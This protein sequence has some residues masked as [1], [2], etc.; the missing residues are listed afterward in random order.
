M[1]AEL[2]TIQKK[3]EDHFAALNA[4]RKD[5]GLPVFALEH[6]LSPEELSTVSTMLRAA[7]KTHYYL[8][9]HWLVWVVY[10]TEQGY[11]YDGDEY[12]NT[13]ER[14]MP[15]WD[16]SWRPN[17]RSWFGRF[18]KTYGGIVPVGRWATFFSIIAW[19]ITHALLPKD[20]QGQ[21]ARTL[22]VLRYHIVS[23]LDQS[24]ADVGRYIAR[25]ARGGSSR[26]DNF[27]EQEE[28]VG[29]IVLGLLDAQAADGDG[30][31]LPQALARIVGDLEKARSARQWLHDTRKAVET[32]RIRGVARNAPGHL[33]GALTAGGGQS[34]HRP[35]IRPS[36]LLRRTSVDEWTLIIELPCL[37]QVAGLS[38]DLSDF[39]S[40]TRCSIAGAS[41]LRPPGWLLDGAQ[42]RALDTW[43]PIDQPVL[44]F[45][46]PNSKMD[47]LL[48]S[49]GRISEGPN[50][51]FRVG[52]DG[53]ATEVIGRIVRP[54][55][56]YVLVSQSDLPDVSFAV[57]TS[58]TCRSAQAI[59]FE[60]PQVVSAEQVGELKA[61]GLSVAETIQVW[62]VGLAARGWDGE[63]TTEWLENEYPC[64]AI[65]HDHPI[66][67]YELRL[68]A[69]PVLRVAAK[70][71]GVPTF[72]KL[73]PLPSGN[74]VLS[75][76]VVRNSA[77]DGPSQP[78]E[79]WISLSVRPPNPW[80]S[81]TIGH[82]GL[83]ASTEPPE[84]TLDEFWE[85]L[86]HLNILGPA[87]RQVSVRVELMDGTGSIIATEQVANLTL[88]LGPD[89]WR[90]A[91]TAFE[92]REKDPWG[93][94][95]AS[96][97]RIVIDGEELGTTNIPLRRDAS[98]VRWVWRSTS[99]STQL[100]LVDDHD[101]DAPL[102][103][104]FRSFARPLEELSIKPE[105][106]AAGFEPFTP[107]GLFT[108]SYGEVRV[109]LV[110]GARKVEGGLGGLLVE[111]DLSA[112]RR[113]RDDALKILQAI[114]AW[115][116]ARQAGAL[117]S[118]RRARVLSRLK[119]CFHYVMC[120]SSWAK[121]E[122]ALR[123]GNSRN[124]AV[125]AMVNCFGSMRPFALVL[126]RDAAK[127]AR[128]PD[129][130]RHREF[131]ALAH[132]YAVAPGVL[133]KPALDLADVLDRGQRP[134]ATQLASMIEHLWD[135]PALTA[136]ARIIQLLGAADA[137]LPKSEGAVE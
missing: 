13:F 17:L 52:T 91:F 69:G 64:F 51:L 67:E 30:A 57:P 68:G 97:G 83:I 119:E 82:S 46:V 37:Q 35:S 117:A 3:L 36:L 105:D 20:L 96:S 38:P 133:S 63:G 10:A 24:P 71:P 22:Y 44:K 92:R 129:H 118:E 53:E 15:L 47:H 9:K 101:G 111:P 8:S 126:T 5:R 27:L 28:L 61:A 114:F 31:I 55:R 112:V 123:T 65:S 90:T 6:G 125:E 66:T 80:V 21:L 134:S 34:A 89:T 42:R 75:V 50:W 23:R 135:H 93:Y 7:L 2:D 115:T 1:S 78:V 127:Y 100:R 77:S 11:D 106:A 137:C 132:R 104:S 131:A 113:S 73:D 109:P 121:A 95:A 98:P 49:E 18:H 16:R 58:L 116:D 72:I 45:E 12:W 120:G 4:V 33:A 74:H 26:F 88:P 62:P 32:A 99:K 43:P 107:G 128:M 59:R 85:G 56:S 54:G 60:V 84:L 40:R 103:V 102:Y 81:G 87:G 70:P 108:A 41:G 29:R 25:M 79:G 94:L 110:V 48:A 136:G 124:A 130:V 86:S 19:P 122:M 39:L 76:R 14:R